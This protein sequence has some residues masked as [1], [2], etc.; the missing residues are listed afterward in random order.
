MAAATSRAC[1]TPNGSTPGPR[2]GHRTVTVASGGRSCH[3]PALVA[4]CQSVLPRPPPTGALPVCS[5][6]RLLAVGGVRRVADPAGVRRARSSSILDRRSRPP[7]FTLDNCAPRSPS[8][9]CS[10]VVLRTVMIAAVVTALCLAVALPTAFFIAKIAPRWMRRGL[11]VSILLPLWAGYL[12][13]GFAW[14]AMLSPHGNSFAAEGSGSGG[15]LVQRVRLD[16]RLRRTRRDLALAYLWLPYMVLPI[17]AGL[18][19]LPT[20]SARRGGRSRR[21]PMR[22]FR[23]VIMPLLLPSIAAG[24]I[25]TF[26]L[27]LGDYIV[28]QLVVG[29]KAAGD[30]RNL[31]RQHAR[32]ARPAVGGR[33]TL[34]PLL[35]IIAYL[36]GHEAPRRVRERLTMGTSSTLTLGPRPHHRGHVGV[37]LHHRCWSSPAVHQ[38][39]QLRGM[40]AEGMDLR[41]VAGGMA[42]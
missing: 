38:Q 36:F 29:R 24:S 12:V 13:K 10:D 5:R 17:Y 20:S 22:T 7:S 40:A 31:H 16:A 28:P 41:L 6:P 4:H 34:W 30:V 42:Q 39:G 23:T 8:G 21:R 32:R 37:P 15:F 9:R 33:V 27:S 25:F 1:P 14:R 18:E 35:I 3:L 11:I 2:S 26:S 19:R